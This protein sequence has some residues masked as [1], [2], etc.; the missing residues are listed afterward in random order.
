MDAVFRSV[1]VVVAFDEVDELVELLLVVEEDEE[2]FDEHGLDVDVDPTEHISLPE[3]DVEDPH[4]PLVHKRYVVLVSQKLS[5]VAIMLNVPPEVSCMQPVVD[6]ELHNPDVVVLE[7]TA[8][9]S[10]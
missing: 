2:E 4:T 1:V 8:S 5:P 9:K 7:P 3:H 6:V 10:T